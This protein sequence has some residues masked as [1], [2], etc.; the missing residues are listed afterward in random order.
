[1]YVFDKKSNHNSNQNIIKNKSS[2]IKFCP[3]SSFTNFLLLTESHTQVKSLYCIM[4][5]GAPHQNSSI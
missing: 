3:S 4:L 1:M 2:I 5:K